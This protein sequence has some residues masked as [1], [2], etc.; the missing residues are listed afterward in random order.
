MAVNMV[1]VRLLVVSTTNWEPVSTTSW[2][3][4]IADE[5]K[6]DVVNNKAGENKQ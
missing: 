5:R 3:V 1:K 2:A 6:H 4:L